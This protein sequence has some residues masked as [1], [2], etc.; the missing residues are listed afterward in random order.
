MWP[1]R[2]AVRSPCSHIKGYGTAESRTQVI[3]PHPHRI[4]L[5]HGLACV[6][7]NERNSING[8]VSRSALSGIYAV[9]GPR[10]PRPPPSVLRTRDDKVTLVPHH[11]ARDRVA[12]VDREPLRAADDVAV[13]VD[14]DGVALYAR[15]AH[16][17]RD[18]LAGFDHVAG[19]DAVPDEPGHLAIARA[20]LNNPEIIVFDEATSDVDTETEELI[21]ESLERLVEE[22]TAFIVAHRLS[23]IQ[24][25][26]EIVVMDEG[27]ISE[28]GG[29]EK[30][31]A[32][33]G[34]YANLWQG[35]A[36]ASP[37]D[38]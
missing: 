14:G 18:D 19:A 34:T 28:Q 12:L 29:H 31:V 21:Q 35:Q 36:E 9:R 4:P 38:D 30:L 17:V 11:E 10:H 33:S 32:G 13:V 3:R 2:V 8:F 24:N 5:P 16:H 22:R 15:R 27:Q 1:P 23:T 37:A 26:D 25:A 20:L 7:T 6:R